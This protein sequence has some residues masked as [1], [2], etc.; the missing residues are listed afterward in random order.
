MRHSG[1]SLKTF[2]RAQM[3]GH[4]RIF[5]VTPNKTSDATRSIACVSVFFPISLGK[6][7]CSAAASAK[8]KIIKAFT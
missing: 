3:P 8:L 7:N 6:T 2:E 4:G 1:V 5:Y